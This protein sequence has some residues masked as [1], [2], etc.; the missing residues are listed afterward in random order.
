[1]ESDKCK[2]KKI[3]LDILLNLHLPIL[4]LKFFIVKE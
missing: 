1:M 2:P 3:T 4:I